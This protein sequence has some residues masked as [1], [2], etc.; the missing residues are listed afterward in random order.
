M[1]KIKWL[2]IVGIVIIAL[3]SG[4]APSEAAIQ[5]AIYETQTALPAPTNTSTIS[6]TPTPTLIP[7]SDI[8]VDDLLFAD[9]DLPPTFSP[10]QITYELPNHVPLN[11]I[12]QPDKVTRIMIHHNNNIGFGEAIIL[13]YESLTELEE[14]YQ[15]VTTRFYNH[16]IMWGETSEGFD[17]GEK[18][19][20]TEKGD[21]PFNSKLTNL[22]SIRCHAIIYVTFLSTNASKEMTTAYATRIDQRISEVVCR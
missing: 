4:C 8:V 9:G 14:A 21:L 19:I 12:P 16:P 7:Y 2:E 11:I 3:F 18:S 20:V 17:V 10:G 15:K 6:P 22:L 13:L 5:R 1:N